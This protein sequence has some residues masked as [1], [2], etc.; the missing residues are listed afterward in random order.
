MII[1]T[2]A[3][4]RA[5]D[6]PSPT[7][8]TDQP[9]I[10]PA[11]VDLNKDAKPATAEDPTAPPPEAPPP[12]P[13]KKT[14]V[15]DTNAGA[16]FFLGQFRKVAPPAPWFHTQLGYE[17]FKFLMVFGEGELAFSDTSNKQGPPRTRAFPMFGFG[18]GAR[19]TIRFTDRFGIYAQGSAGMMKA[20]VAT[21]ALGSIGFRGA[22]DLDL[23]LA[24][25][26]GVEWYQIDR[27]FAL[28]LTGGLRSMRGF[29]KT[30]TTQD[31]PLAMDAGLALRY[32][33]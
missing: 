26:L 10:N 21:N 3:M 24:A 1:S 30:G 28:G 8:S 13:Y 31:T 29:E 27:H 6:D 14:L 11:Q 25:R 18:G 33:F 32:A 15:L 4:A 17:I 9:A 22:E 16:L 12:P 2:S 5:A 19:F 20:H 23:Y 7:P